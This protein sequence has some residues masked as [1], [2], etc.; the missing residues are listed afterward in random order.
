MTTI[1]DLRVRVK[2]AL[3][4]TGTSAEPGYEDDNLDLHITQAVAEFSTFLP[5]EASAD[6]TL[7][8]G[9]RTLNLGALARLLRVV[10]VET[11]LGQWPR[12]LVE[13]DRWNTTLTL[14]LGP[15]AAAAVVRVYYEQAH[16]VDAVASTLES[17]HEY[18]VVEGAAAFAVLARATAAANAWMI[19]SVQPQTY[20]HLRIAQSRLAAWRSSLRRLGGRTVRQR[21]YVPAGGP[22]QRSVVGSGE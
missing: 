4:I 2:A 10:A 17:E 14:D 7:A 21:F 9:S 16:L 18:A 22:A 19:S 3:G 8:A 6:L 11:P 20:Q 15:P 12:S 5:V 1:A 13:F